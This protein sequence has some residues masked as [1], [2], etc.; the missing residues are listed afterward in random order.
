M[1]AIVTGR[2]AGAPRDDQGHIPVLLTEVIE[3]LAVK[4]G[5]RY[6]DATFGGGG[7]AEAIL[8]ES[9]PDGWLLAIDA[10]PAAQARA[11]RVARVFGDRFSFRRGNFRDLADIAPDAGFDA[12]DGVLFDLGLSSFQFDERDR[13][14]S[15][16]SETPLDMRLDPNAPGPTAWDIV[17]SWDEADI[18]DV[19]FRYGEE[20][21]SR[22]IA[23]AIVNRRAEEPI[24]NNA[25]LASIVE[26]ALGGRRGARIHPAT[27]TLQGIRI[28]V[29]QEL[30]ALE[31]GLA[32]GL[33]LLHP[34]G[35]VAVISFHSLEDRIVKQYFQRESR[36]CIC[37]PELP[38]CQC[39][40]TASLRVI[41]RRPITPDDD[42]RR[43]NPRS[44]SAKLRVA[45][46]I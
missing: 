2:D 27:R 39:G 7:H 19:I 18:A 46:R 41:T 33:T 4:P 44:S 34:G 8:R 40:H 23:R 32:D 11:E 25:E 9:G 10:D 5:G 31:T 35:R 38:V 12:V 42:E 1:V 20:R 21:R 6:V 29:N 24:Q 28:A 45:E 43:V 14:F 37:P 22:R 17:N 26:R 3:H 36:D 15:L 30:T 13:G 16:Y